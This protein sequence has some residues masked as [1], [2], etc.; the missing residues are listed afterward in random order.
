M[1]IYHHASPLKVIHKWNVTPS[2]TCKGRW[3]IE[4]FAGRPEKSKEYQERFY[5][6]RLLATTGM[7]E[8]MNLGWE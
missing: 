2:Q 1:C 8:V 4:G 5:D 7:N 6:I 3:S